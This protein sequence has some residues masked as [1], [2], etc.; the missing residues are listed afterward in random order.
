MKSLSKSVNQLHQPVHAEIYNR[1]RRVCV[2]LTNRS[3]FITDWRSNFGR[4][5]IQF[6]RREPFERGAVSA[7]VETSHDDRERCWQNTAR[8]DN[9]RPDS[10]DCRRRPEPARVQQTRGNS[11][12]W[13]R[14]RPGGEHRDL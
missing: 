4:Q 7:H 13:V 12:Q 2:T 9:I 11:S 6:P 1:R 10:V 8:D 3:T 5:W 14:P